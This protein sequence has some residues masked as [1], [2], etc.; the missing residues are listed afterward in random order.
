MDVGNCEHGGL[1][2]DPKPIL[3]EAVLA[4]YRVDMFSPRVEVSCV[5]RV[6]TKACQCNTA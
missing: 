5:V 4:G 3:S 6:D 1:A 2:T